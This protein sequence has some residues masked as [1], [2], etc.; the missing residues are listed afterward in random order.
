M[1]VDLACIGFDFTR[2][3]IKSPCNLKGLC[4]YNTISCIWQYTLIGSSENKN[5]KVLRVMET[6]YLRLKI[7]AIWLVIS[8]KSEIQHLF[9]YEG[10]LLYVAWGK[11]TYVNTQTT[12]IHKGICKSFC[13]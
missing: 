9:W 3:D 10:A 5:K 2:K 11:K 7:R 4:T 12:K 6:P 8:P 1:T 13:F